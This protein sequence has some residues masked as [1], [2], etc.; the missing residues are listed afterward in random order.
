MEMVAKQVATGG[1]MYADDWRLC[2]LDLYDHSNSEEA[3]GSRAEICQSSGL[4]TSPGRDFA[5][6]KVFIKVRLNELAN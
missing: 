1:I 2:L 5:I 6:S 3:S 4:L